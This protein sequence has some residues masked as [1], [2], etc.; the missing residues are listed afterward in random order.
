[1]L[2]ETADSTMSLNKQEIAWR[3]AYAQRLKPRSFVGGPDFGDFMA[4]KF[5]GRVGVKT[6]SGK[7]TDH[8]ARIADCEHIGGQIPHDNTAGAHD[9]IVADAHAGA[10]HTRS[11]EPDVVADDDGLRTFK[12]SA[13]RPRIERMQRGVDVDPGADLSLVS[14]ADRI[15]V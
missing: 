14:D 11:A 7:L 2:R 4:T 1:M 13:S 12:S 6:R 15:A 5:R 9:G 8:C 3:R 10:D